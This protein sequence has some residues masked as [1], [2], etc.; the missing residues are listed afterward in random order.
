MRLNRKNRVQLIVFGLISLLAVGY[1]GGNYAGLDRLFG[2]RGYLVQVRLTDSGGIFVNAEVAYRGVTVGR[3]HA[4][5]LDE[6]G[7]TVDLDIENSAPRIPADTDAVV[8][9][10]SAVGEQYVDLRPRSAGGPYLEAGSVIDSSR[11][12]VPIAPETLL[13]NLD[14]L[15]SSVDTESLTT[16]VDET[17]LAF[18]GAGPDLQRLLDAGGSF[19]ATAQ[20]NL[21]QTRELLERGRAVLETQRRNGGNIRSIATGFHDIAEQLRSSDP[22]LRRVVDRAPELSRE[23]SELLATS[24]TSLSVVIANLLTTAQITSVRTDA[25]EQLFVALPVAASFSKSVTSNGE[26]HLG[27]VPTFFDP[28]ACTKGYEGTPR[29][30]ADQVEE[31]EPNVQAYCAEPPGSPSNVRGAQNAPFAGMPVEPPGT[32]EPPAEGTGGGPDGEPREPGLP[33]LLDLAGEPSASTGLGGLLG[34]AG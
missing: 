13:A 16:V 5:H 15:V 34:L 26:G 19:T 29:R 14:K 20:R 30:A 8:A 23:V 17:H 32:G 27:F 31:T 33:G 1:A 28:H 9:N 12:G 6:D 10:R 4:L 21:P 2:N 24:G 11:T 3:V 7:V 18:S 25:L 22:D